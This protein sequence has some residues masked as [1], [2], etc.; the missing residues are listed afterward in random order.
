MIEYIIITILTILLGVSIYCNVKLGMT[1][2]K[3]QDSIEESL[4]ILDERYASISKVLEIPIFYDSAE[5]K[6][7]L[8]DIDKSRDSVLYIA[9]LLT[10]VQEV[11]DDEEQS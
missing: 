8:Q 7:V 10:S 6:S 4:D 2:L 9:N 1:V 3:I 11:S 5:I